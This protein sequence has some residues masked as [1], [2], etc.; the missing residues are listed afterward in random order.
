MHMWMDGW[1]GKCV[2]VLVRERGMVTFPLLL[3]FTVLCTPNSLS[4]DLIFS[5]A[6]VLVRVNQLS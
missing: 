3:P 5:L 2:C 1:V 4:N 6:C